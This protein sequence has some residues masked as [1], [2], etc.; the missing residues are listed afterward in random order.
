MKLLLQL[1]AYLRGE[2]NKIYNGTKSVYNSI[3]L[4]GKTLSTIESERSTAI[5]TAIQTNVTDKLG[6]AS[7]IATLDTNG[8]VPTSQLPSSVLG[9]LSYQGVWDASTGSYPTT[10]SKGFYYVTSVA[11][12]ISSKAYDIGDWL[13]Y[14]GTAWDRVDNVD[15]TVVFN[16]RTGYNITMQESDVIN[17]IGSYTEFTTE[18]ETGLSAGAT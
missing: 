1:A 16:G 5:N 13:V 9:G 15:P 12:T 18:F 2:F 11:G 3:R 8:Q 10:P 6:V 14:N 4:G 7:G 17:L